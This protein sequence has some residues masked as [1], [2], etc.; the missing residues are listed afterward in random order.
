[1]LK[2][3]QILNGEM[4]LPFNSLNTIYTITV[5]DTETSLNIDYKI[6]SSDNISIFGNN[7]TEELNE[8]VI[9]VYND[10]D[11]MSYYL[12]VYKEKSLETAT[13]KTVFN[14]LEINK[15][16]LPSFVIPSIASACFV[17][18][19]LFFTLLFKKKKN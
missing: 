4:P 13:D 12:Y 8:V 14:S 11:M 16:A 6:D 7:L 5:K 18:I 2:D 17:V 15:E 1:M 19:L 10:T 3:L 9:T